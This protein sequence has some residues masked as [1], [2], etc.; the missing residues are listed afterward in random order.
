[1][2]I[3]FHTEMKGKLHEET[4]SGPTS[5]EH[6]YAYILSVCRPQFRHSGTTYCWQKGKI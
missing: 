2:L 3:T 4:F 5:D 6:N 1:M